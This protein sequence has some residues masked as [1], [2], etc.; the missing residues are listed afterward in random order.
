MKTSGIILG[1]VG[2]LLIF[3]A[4]SFPDYINSFVSRSNH[5]GNISQNTV[6]VVILERGDQ[7]FGLIM[8]S[9][10]GRV[11]YVPAVACKSQPD[12]KKMVEHLVKAGK[13]HDIDV[14]QE[15]GEAREQPQENG[16]L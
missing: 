7:T 13:S 10:Q 3:L 2:L 5:G 12:C 4:M 9:D 1:I 16:A 14:T 11:A 6:G 8:V 15:D